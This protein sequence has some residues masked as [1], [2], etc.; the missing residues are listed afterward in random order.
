MMDVLPSITRE[1][2]RRYSHATR[3]LD[4]TQSTYHR[5][6]VISDSHTNEIV[7]TFKEG[8][9]NRATLDSD[10]LVIGKLTQGS[11]SKRGKGKDHGLTL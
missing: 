3:N 11:D 1:V 8:Q 6:G 7:N 10:P 5:T 2:C 4:R 9:D